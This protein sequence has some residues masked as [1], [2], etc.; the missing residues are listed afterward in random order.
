[1][2]KYQEF[3]TLLN[4]KQSL[5]NKHKLNLWERAQKIKELEYKMLSIEKDVEARFQV[6]LAEC[7]DCLYQIPKSYL[8]ASTSGILR[9]KRCYEEAK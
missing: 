3:S 5:I 6:D 4:F 8:I 1:M 2:I 9:C 7:E